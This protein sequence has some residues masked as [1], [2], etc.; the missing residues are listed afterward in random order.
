LGIN[1]GIVLP[2][3]IVTFWV[4]F[5][6]GHSNITVEEAP[7]LLHLFPS[8]SLHLYKIE[9]LEGAR[10]TIQGFGMPFADP[11]DQDIEAIL[12]D[13]GRVVLAKEDME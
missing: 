4:K 2:T 8:E 12:K 5:P 7:Q 9:F 11:N 1:N 10:P 13:T 3:S 6:R